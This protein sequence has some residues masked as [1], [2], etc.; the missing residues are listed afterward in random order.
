MD[1]MDQYD[2]SGQNGPN[3]TNVDWKDRIELNQTKVDKMDWI[4]PKWTEYNQSGSN[5]TKID[6]SGPNKTKID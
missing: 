2:R 3:K 5:M 4:G 6:W 1:R